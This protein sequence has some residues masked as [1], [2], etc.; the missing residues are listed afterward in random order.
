MV[1]TDDEEIAEIARN[2][3]ANVPFARSSENANDFATT[4]DVLVEVLENYQKLNQTFE[5][6]CC[7]YPTAPF[8]SAEILQKSYQKLQN[9]DFDSVYPVQKFSFPP[10]RSVVFEDD[11]LRWQNPENALTRSQDLTPL[12]HDAGQFYFFKTEEFLQNRSILTKN[13]GGIIISE[14]A[15]H[16]IDNEEDWAVAEFKY[17]LKSKI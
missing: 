9:E 1:S 8:V 2:C 4:V 3:G 6:V 17:Q 13:T 16:D 11:K 7:I 14:M 15:A 5:T 10:Q 12:Y